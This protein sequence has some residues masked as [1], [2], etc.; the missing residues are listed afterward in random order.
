MRARRFALPAAV[1]ALTLGLATLTTPASAAGPSPSPAPHPPAYVSIAEGP[2]PAYP[3]VVYI[4]LQY[5]CYGDP[6]TV[7][8]TVT[9]GAAKASGSAAIPCQGEVDLPVGLRLTVPEDAEGFP[10]GV[11]PVEVRASIPGQASLVTTAQVEGPPVLAPVLVILDASPEEVIKGKKITVVGVIRRGSGGDPVS[12]KTALEFRPDGGDW[13]KVK[14][15]T[16]SE[17][18]IL[19]TTVKATRSGNFRFRYA[20]SPENEPATSSPDHIVVRPKPKAYKSCA[21]LTKVYKHGVG[22]D[23]ATEVGLG[24]T[25]W[26]RNTATYKK[27]KKFDRDHDGVACEKA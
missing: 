3:R 22:K 5:S 19:S 10:P 21:A 9:A 11:Y 26:T 1:A 23:G 2:S 12:V 24:V 8:V 18:G 16:S 4:Q 15:V 14:S 13:H 27:N 6:T 20:G 25:N 17:A 7:D